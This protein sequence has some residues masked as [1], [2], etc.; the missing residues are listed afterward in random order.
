MAA[1]GTRPTQVRLTPA[2]LETFHRIRDT[3][4]FRSLADAIREA[5]R[6][7]ADHHPDPSQ[8]VPARSKKKRETGL[9]V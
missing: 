2:E 3:R 6:Y 1:R 4:G 8:A 7:W 5:G 9:D